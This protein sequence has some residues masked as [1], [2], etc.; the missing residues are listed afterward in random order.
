MI[1]SDLS[2]EVN[3]FELNIHMEL[4]KQLPP[5]NRFHHY[6]SHVKMVL[7]LNRSRLIFPQAELKQ[8]LHRALVK[9]AYRLTDLKQMRSIEA[10]QASRYSLNV[11]RYYLVNKLKN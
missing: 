11:L 5:S 6:I 10:M 9:M 1:F 3:N 4:A 2:K 7:D 8:I